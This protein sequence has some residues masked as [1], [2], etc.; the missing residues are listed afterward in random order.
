MFE[1]A[2]C[3]LIGLIFGAGLALLFVMPARVKFA[4]AEIKSEEHYTAIRRQIDEENAVNRRRHDEAMQEIGAL[5]KQVRDVEASIEQQQGSEL[6]KM[7]E[8]LKG[9]AGDRRSQNHP[10]VGS[11][12]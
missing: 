10:P 7:S 1:N 8:L 6:S 3:I 2:I 11:Q 5:W 12:I 9:I 4:R